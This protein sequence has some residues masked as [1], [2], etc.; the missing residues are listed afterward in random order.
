MIIVGA[1][2][3]VGTA[4][5]GTAKTEWT[6]KSPLTGGVATA[7][8]GGFGAPLKWA[9]YDHL[10]VT[11]RA[12]K[13]VYLTVFDDEVQIH[14]ATGIWFKELPITP[15]QVYQYKSSFD[16]KCEIYSFKV[17]KALFS[18]MGLAPRFTAL[19]KTPSVPLRPTFPP[20]PAIGLTTKPIFDTIVISQS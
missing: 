1:G 16:K 3:F 10:L 19:F 6:M 9:G 13:P 12:E 20:I 7:S 11:G 14:D 5:A 8:S 17:S 18:A 4:L 15:E 2:P